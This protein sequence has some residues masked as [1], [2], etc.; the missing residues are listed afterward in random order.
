MKINSMSASFSPGGENAVSLHGG[1]NLIK[2]HDNREASAWQSFI[3]A[4]LF[5]SHIDNLQ[6]MDNGADVSPEGTVSLTADSCD[7][8]LTRFTVKEGCPLSEFTARYT[9]SS[10]EV[11]GLNE[12]NAGKRITGVDE[13]LFGRSAFLMSDISEA[14]SE[15]EISRRTENILSGGDEHFSFSEAEEKLVSWQ[16]VRTDNDNGL[17]PDADARY[18]EL[19]RRLDAIRETSENLAEAEAALRDCSGEC[20]I[21]ERQVH[22]ARK[23]HRSDILSAISEARAETETLT[24]KKDAALKEYNLVKNSLRTG[25]FCGK[26]AEEAKKAA[27]E[28]T[29]LCKDLAGRA[30]KAPS[31]VLMLVLFCLTVLGIAVYDL[32]VKHFAVLIIT[33]LACLTAIVF[34]LRYVS[35]KR[36]ART[37][38]E[39]LEDILNKYN[40]DSSDEISEH[41]S[42]YISILQQYETAQNNAERATSELKAAR[43]QLKY[44]EN[45]AADELTDL[46]GTE[47]SAALGKELKKARGRASSLALVVS[48]EKSHLA[49]LGNPITLAGELGCVTEEKKRLQEEYDAITLALKTLTDAEKEFSAKISHQLRKTAQDYVSFMDAAGDIKLEYVAAKL[50]V[51]DLAMPEGRLFPLFVGGVFDLLSDEEYSKA[52]RLLSEIARDRQVILFTCK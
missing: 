29:A 20:R 46:S 39:R 52:V 43:E 13:S 7:I 24:E 37:A 19:S 22:L 15:Y 25:P 32:S 49:M 18:A 47:S 50:A 51:C 1:L 41:L 10:N 48:A 44:L 2:I 21:L 35:Q 42:A 17:L 9:G 31:P 40:A 34:L 45:K 26:S 27:E 30:E 11:E 12:K 36:E 28:D 8:T 16:K 3:M 4:M 33:C 5:G 14:A 38:A 23:S 6:Y